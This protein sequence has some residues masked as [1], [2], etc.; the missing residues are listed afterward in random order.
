MI[1]FPHK[2]ISR[3]CVNPANQI[4]GCLF[5]KVISSYMCIMHKPA[6]PTAHNTLKLCQFGLQGKHLLYFPQKMY[7]FIAVP[8][9][10]LFIWR[11]VFTFPFV[12]PSLPLRIVAW[13]LQTFCTFH[14]YPG[15]LYCFFNQPMS[16]LS[17]NHIF[18]CHYLLWCW[19]PPSTATSPP[20]PTVLTHK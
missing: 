4:T 18:S 2:M 19:R 3:N 14:I 1:A 17:P 20:S 8:Q 10:L 13:D 7:K 16:F 5:E 6:L 12:P 9:V 11:F 15:I